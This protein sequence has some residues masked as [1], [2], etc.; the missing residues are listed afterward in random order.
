MTNEP[1]EDGVGMTDPEKS[2][3]QIKAETHKELSKGL[4]ARLAH[5]DP[6]FLG[7]NTPPISTFE[8][9]TSRIAPGSLTDD[10]EDIRITERGFAWYG[11]AAITDTYGNSVEVYQSSSAVSECLWLR[12]TPRGTPNQPDAQGQST[13]AHLDLDAAIEMHRRIGEWIASVSGDGVSAEEDFSDE[14]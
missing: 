6:D 2:L 10:G 13:A 14:E 12:V 3:Q 4:S 1:I 7:F 9:N 11:A 5:R 8:D